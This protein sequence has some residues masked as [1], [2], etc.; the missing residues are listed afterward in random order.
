[1]IEVP[2]RLARYSILSELGRGGFA[3][4]Y[5]AQDTRLERRVAL[6]VIRGEFSQDP[7]FSKRFEQEAYSAAS[8]HHPH[9]VT[10]YDYGNAM[11]CLTWLCA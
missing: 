4:V 8:L 5:E 10:I 7:S 11:A 9:I 6:K 3:T 1:M 2:D